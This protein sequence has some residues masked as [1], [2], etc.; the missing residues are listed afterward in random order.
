VNLMIDLGSTLAVD[1]ESRSGSVTVAGAS[2]K[3]QCLRGGRPERSVQA[4]HSSLSRAAA[5][6]FVC[7]WPEPSRVAATAKIVWNEGSGMRRTPTAGP[8]LAAQQRGNKEVTVTL[9]VAWIDGAMC[10]SLPRQ[11]VTDGPAR[12]AVRP[13]PQSE[14]CG[15]RLRSLHRLWG[16]GRVWR[17]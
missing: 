4:C 16:S 2:V 17:L 12:C 14:P 9:A 13:E 1:T 3:A 11:A 10:R 6:R 8:I 5:G 7:R 15:R